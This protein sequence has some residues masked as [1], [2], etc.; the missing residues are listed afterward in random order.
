M[1]QN[2]TII[3]L[4]I[5][6]K[7]SYRYIKNLYQKFKIIIVDNSN[8]FELKKII[9]N[10]YPGVDIYL[11]QIMDTVIKLIMELNLLRQ[12]IFNQQSRCKRS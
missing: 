12:N 6:A 7:F 5:R 2:V 11:I 3:I 4:I 10:N 1:N 9:K 8:D